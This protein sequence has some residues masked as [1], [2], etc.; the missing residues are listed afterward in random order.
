VLHRRRPTFDRRAA[1]HVTVRM[2][3]GVWNLRSRRSFSR[4]QQALGAA[5]VRF[6]VRFVRFAVLGNHIHLVVEAPDHRSLGRAMQGFGV[7]LA[8]AMN[9]MMGRTGSV[10]QERYHAHRLRTPTE[11]RRAIEYVRHNHA[12]H[13]AEIGKPVPTRWIDPYSSDSPELAIV[14][15]PPIGWLLRQ[16]WQRGRPA[17]S[18]SGP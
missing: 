2:R 8:R 4:I 9:A 15:P 6:D 10:L 12:R 17:R 11:T 18:G 5:A 16:G 7:R 1:L 13:M 3:Q 14:L